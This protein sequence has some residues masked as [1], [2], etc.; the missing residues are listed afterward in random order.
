MRMSN[1]E[2]NVQYIADLARLEL[3]PAET[4]IF[5]QQLAKVLEYV[6]Q[7]QELDV[8]GVEPMAN[9]TAISNVLREDLPR[10]GLSQEAALSIAPAKIRQL[11]KVPKVIE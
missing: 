6:C 11:F 1:Q 8:A 4:S 9:A 3:D 7:L 10:P 5:E 2:I